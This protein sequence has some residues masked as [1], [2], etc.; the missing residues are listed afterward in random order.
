MLH[1]FLGSDLHTARTHALALA[2]QQVGDGEV[3]RIDADTYTVGQLQDVVGATS[4]FG[5]PTVYVI[6]TPSSQKDF[7]DD[8]INHLAAFAESTNTFVL[9]E[10]GVLAP[11]KKKLQ[12]HAVTFEEYKKPAMERF[13]AFALADSL[14][15]KNK[16]LL[17]MQLQEARAAGLSAEELIGTLWWQLKLLQLAER[18]ASATEAGVKDFPYNKAKRALPNFKPGEIR[19]LSNQLLMVYHDGHAGRRDISLGLERWVLTL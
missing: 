15:Q 7:Y 11:E 6:D 9:I 12:K 13:N 18:T 8:V 3:E 19:T 1:V 5:V 17:W 2:Q 16:K 4:L 10:A 14:L